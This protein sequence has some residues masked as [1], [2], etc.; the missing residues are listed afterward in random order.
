[1]AVEWKKVA[2]TDDVPG[3]IRWVSFVIDGGGSAITTGIKGDI[4]MPA[5]TIVAV[6]MLADQS[7]SIVVD[8][9]KDTY[10][11]FPPTD[12]DSITSSTPPTITTATKSTDS[13]LTSWTTNVSDGD[14]IRLNVDSCTTITRCTVSIKITA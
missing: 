2:F 7:G 6:D 9:W 14:I 1:M 5:C 8:L 10:A 4:A 13:T 11:N 3:K 12:A